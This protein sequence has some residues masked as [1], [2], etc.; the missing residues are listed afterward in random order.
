MKILREYKASLPQG[1]LHIS[2]DDAGNWYCE[3]KG[4][5]WKPV[6]KS[7]NPVWLDKRI[8]ERLPE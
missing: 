7:E 6:Q 5:D 3:L 8:W 2:L 1:T 4:G